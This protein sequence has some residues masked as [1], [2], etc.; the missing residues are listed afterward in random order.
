MPKVTVVIPLYNTEA[1]IAD[2]LDSVLGQTFQDWECIVV[3]DGSTDRSVEIVARY[4]KRDPR[5][6]LVHQPNQGVTVARNTGAAHACPD[7]EYLFFLD[8]DDMLE[9]EALERLVAYLEAHPEVGLVGCQFTRIDAQGRPIKIRN[10]L[11]LSLKGRTR[12][13]PGRW[14]IPRRLKPSEPYTPFLTFFCGTGQGPFALYRRSVFVQTAGW[15]P[16]FNIWHDDTDMFCQMSL[17]A[18]VHYI[19]DRLYRYRDHAS[20]RSKDPRVVETVRL[21]QEKWRSYTPKNKREARLLAEA[22]WYHDYRH[23]PFRY[24]WV[25]LQGLVESITERSWAKLRW[26]VKNLMIGLRKVI[27]AFLSSS[28]RRPPKQYGQ[29]TFAVSLFV[30]VLLG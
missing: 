3:N 22:I 26:G 14:G 28:G 21:L 16:R 20:N 18:D 6:R 23:V 25:G 12:W 29:F 19:P 2:A 9:P 27:H 4:A 17:I 30:F 1:Y 11:K 8:A 10:P 15:D 24:I 5:I 13:V 7:G